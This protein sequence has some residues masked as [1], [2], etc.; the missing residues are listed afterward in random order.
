MPGKQNDFLLFFFRSQNLLSLSE[1]VHIHGREEWDVEEHGHQ[2]KEGEAEAGIEA[3]RE[4]DTERVMLVGVDQ[5][6][7]LTQQLTRYSSGVGDNE[8]SISGIQLIKGRKVHYCISSP[9]PCEE[10][11]GC[12]DQVDGVHGVPDHLR[13]GPSEQ[14]HGEADG[15]LSGRQHVQDQPGHVHSVN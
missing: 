8:E 9:E 13:H 2:D 5:A 14:Q 4:A 15:E 7:E 10:V 1:H 12:G 6:L 3:V 11:G